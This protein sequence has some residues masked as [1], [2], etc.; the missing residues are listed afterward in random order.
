MLCAVP[1]EKVASIG[2]T[3]SSQL[4]VGLTHGEACSLLCIAHFLLSVYLFACLRKGGKTMAPLE[5]NIGWR[6]DLLPFSWL[7]PNI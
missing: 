1:E 4:S 6:A 3:S 5:T 2:H 7:W